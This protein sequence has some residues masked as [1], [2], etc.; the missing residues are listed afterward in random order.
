MPVASK[1]WRFR[2]FDGGADLEDP[3]LDERYLLD[4]AIRSDSFLTDVGGMK[5]PFECTEDHLL[6]LYNWYY[7]FCRVETLQGTQDGRPEIDRGKFRRAISQYLSYV[8]PWPDHVDD[9]YFNLER[10]AM[11]TEAAVEE[12]APPVWDEWYYSG[13]DIERSKRYGF[14][15]LAD[16]GYKDEQGD[17]RARLLSAGGIRF[18]ITWGYYLDTN[19]MMNDKFNGEKEAVMEF[20]VERWCAIYKCCQVRLDDRS[21][22]DGRTP[23]Y[24]RELDTNH[25]MGYFSTEA[26]YHADG[27]VDDDGYTPLP[28]GMHRIQLIHHRDWL[29]RMRLR[30][31]PPGLEGHH[32]V[33]STTSDAAGDNRD[34]HSDSSLVPMVLWPRESSE[35]E[36]ST[37]QTIP[38]DISDGD[39]KLPFDTKRH[40]VADCNCTSDSLLDHCDYDVL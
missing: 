20:L 22:A 7:H 8:I 29:C 1:D 27:I 11:L 34:T 18:C 19:K 14:G 5:L 36:S 39:Q 25:I 35:D 32:D 15:H 10:Q 30:N 16:F 26:R 4:Y 31:L 33:A 13:V 12:I 9:F 6:R 40:P 23:W 38:F 24:R 28:T 17:T 2:D 3:H 37:D 21:L